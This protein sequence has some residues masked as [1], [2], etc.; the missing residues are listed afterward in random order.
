MDASKCQA[1]LV[2]SETGSFSAAAEQLNYTQ[3]GITRMISSLEEELDFP[4]FIRNKKG[5]RLT[6]N[7]QLMLPYFREIVDANQVAVEVSEEIKGLVRG[8]ITI[9]CYF[10]V[11][12]MWM[13][14]LLKAFYETYPSIQIT[15]LE[16]GNKEIAKWLAEK[17]VDIC[18]CAE[19]QDSGEYSWK[20]L[21][22]DPLVAWLPKDHPKAKQKTYRI[23]DLET[24]EFIHTLPGQDT[25]QDRLIK[26]EGLKL[27]TRFTT[28]DG[29]TTY[30]LVKAGLGVSF[31]Q[32]MI[33]QDWKG[34]VVQLPLTP[35]RF[36]S[37]GLA[38]PKQK[39]TSPAVQRFLKCMEAEISD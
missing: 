2:A 26:Q 11:S 14:S 27:K 35:P 18:L 10:S 19:P 36:V 28:K 8:S 33:A 9:G 5:V 34:D 3:S 12:S 7:G 23:K 25:D 6:E 16:G 37:L 38:L 17:S 29:F 21:Y 4:I 32:A 24:E 13:P 20:E 15:L 22:R 31:N 1:V 30:Q 39:P